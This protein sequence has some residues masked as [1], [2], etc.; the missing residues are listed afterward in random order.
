[1]GFMAN[2]ERLRERTLAG[3][4]SPVAALVARTRVMDEWRGFPELDPDL[5]HELLPDAWPR[6]AARELF[7][8]TYDLL[9]PLAAHRV[10][11]IIAR[12]SPELAV[13]ATHHSSELQLAAGGDAEP[14]RAVPVG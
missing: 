1:M 13:Y 9:G 12:Y 10:R 7:T 5:P 2:A 3:Q 6:A 14:A 4:V 11:Q 8:T